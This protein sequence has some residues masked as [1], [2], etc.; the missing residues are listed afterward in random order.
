MKKILAILLALL[1]IALIVSCE[2]DNKE[3]DFNYEDLVGDYVYWQ[4]DINESSDEYIRFKFLVENGSNLADVYD[5]KASDSEYSMKSVPVKIKGS[6]LT[7]SSKSGGDYIYKA[8]LDVDGDTST[9]TLTQIGENTLFEK[10]N[11]LKTVVLTK[12]KLG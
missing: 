1:S 10:H 8:V 5:R 2:A 9:L 7:F 11:T 3:P 6:E 4:Y 12:V